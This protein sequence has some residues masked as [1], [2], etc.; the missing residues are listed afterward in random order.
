MVIS[1]ILVFFR[2]LQT[3]KVSES[4]GLG[5]ADPA[6]RSLIYVRQLAG[7]PDGCESGDVTCS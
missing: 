5:F 2:I 7:D 1:P 6:L 3:K 4:E